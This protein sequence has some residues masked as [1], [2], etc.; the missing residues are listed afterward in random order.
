MLTIK[1]SRSPTDEL[2]IN[3]VLSDKKPTD[4]VPDPQK[5]PKA[6]AYNANFYKNVLLFFE[7]WLKCLSILGENLF[8]TNNQFLS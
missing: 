4:D 6:K 8:S 5:Y 2:K 7:Y 3:I 1:K